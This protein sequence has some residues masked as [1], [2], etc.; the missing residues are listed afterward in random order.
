MWVV[1]RH[2]SQSCW[3]YIIPHELK[4]IY[5]ASSQVIIEMCLDMHI[6]Y[7]LFFMYRKTSSISHTKSQS[8]NVSCFLLQLS[9][10]NPLKPG[11]KLRMKM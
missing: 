7:K 8:L 5:D 2:D 1:S 11:V 6:A 4:F 3:L 9:A 10:L